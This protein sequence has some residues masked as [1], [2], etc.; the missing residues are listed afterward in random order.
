MM[1]EAIGLLGTLVTH[2]QLQWHHAVHDVLQVW[3][4]QTF[5][6]MY[7]PWHMHIHG[8]KSN[9]QPHTPAVNKPETS[10]AVQV[11]EGLKS[12]HDP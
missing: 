6:D 10:V 3:L 1:M 9:S 11:F 2:W 5:S 8:A 12:M 7:D 4:S